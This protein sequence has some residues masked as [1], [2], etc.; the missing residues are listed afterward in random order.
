M[1][2]FF[3][4]LIFLAKIHYFCIVLNEIDKYNMLIYRYL[5]FFLNFTFELKTLFIEK[6]NKIINT[7]KHFLN[8]NFIQ[9]AQRL[10]SSKFGRAQNW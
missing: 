6:L 4:I 8:E 10:L 2:L 3:Q 9:V 1:I 5:C 7:N